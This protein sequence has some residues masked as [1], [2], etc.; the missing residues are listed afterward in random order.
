MPVSILLFATDLIS[1]ESSTFWCVT[2]VVGTCTCGI[3]EG[4]CCIIVT[5]SSV[6]PLFFLAGDLIEILILSISKS[7]SVA[8]DFATNFI[9]VS[10]MKIFKDFDLKKDFN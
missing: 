9:K 7:T 5:G 8:P 4:V 3:A 2:F 10:S 6:A 1:L